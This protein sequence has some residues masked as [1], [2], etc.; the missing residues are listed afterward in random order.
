MYS[1]RSPPAVQ[2]RKYTQVYERRRRRRRRGALSV[3][4]G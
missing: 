2:A 4:V 1:G 3:S